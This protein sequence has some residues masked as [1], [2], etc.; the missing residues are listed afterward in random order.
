MQPIQ[1]N[2][3]QSVPE[4]AYVSERSL[5][6]HQ[7]SVLEGFVS[8]IIA[9]TPM[10]RNEVWLMLKSHLGVKHESKL[11]S[12]HFPAA[13]RFLSKYLET[14]NNHQL[15]R[16]I[17]NLLPS[18]DN[19]QRVYDFIQQSFNLGGLNQLNVEQLNQVLLFLKNSSSTML[20]PQPWAAQF[21]ELN[22][23]VSKL[24]ATT[25]KSEQIIRESLRNILGVKTNRQIM[26]KDY[27]LLI[28]LLHVQQELSLRSNITFSLLKKTLEE[29]FELQEWNAFINDSQL[30]F[31]HTP[32]T[33]LASHQVQD[34]LHKAIAFKRKKQTPSIKN[35]FQ[36]QYNHLFMPFV[37]PMK[38]TNPERA[39]ATII[40]ALVILVS[41][42]MIM[43]AAN[44]L[45]P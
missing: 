36:L 25:G 28:S 11:L 34:I 4:H 39:Q 10:H 21:N 17:E 33:I 13:E 31:Q 37:E 18:G 2:T 5:S 23:L 26:P 41:C 27:P 40:L 38:V 20:K 1:G 6:P 29:L 7:Y 32:Q 9:L 44:S 8:R 19:R 42:I 15:T 30:C 45:L 22:M 14:L 12:G 3:P 35:F 24:S 43:V 16:Q